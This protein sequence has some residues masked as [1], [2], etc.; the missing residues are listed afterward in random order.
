MASS[1]DEGETYADTVSDYYFCDGD[2]EPLSFSKLPWQWDESEISSSTTE[3]IFLR[4]T[5]DNGLQKLYK[6][7]K[8]WKYDLSKP[9]PE[10]SVLSKDNHWIK[11]Q[12]PRKS[13]ENEIRT[14]LIT[15]HCLS[16]LKSKPEASA[17]SLWDHLSK[18]FRYLHLLL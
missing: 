2:D 9:N 14:I 18:V 17:K 8:A 3:P 6:A 11:L 10:I 5:A 15:V 7:V 12:K 1:D 4:G 16:Y 13:F